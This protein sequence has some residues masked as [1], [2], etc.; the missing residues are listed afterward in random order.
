[1]VSHWPLS[2]GKRSLAPPL[3]EEGALSDEALDEISARLDG[4][5]GRDILDLVFRIESCV[6]STEENKIT[7][8]I[9]NRVADTM[10][11][12]RPWFFMDAP[13]V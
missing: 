9:I 8:D 11:R 4:F 12:E 2:D 7:T 3:I 1:M 13:A 6:L 5:S 10:L